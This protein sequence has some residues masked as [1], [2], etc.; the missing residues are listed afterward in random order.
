M[1]QDKT[2]SPDIPEG[3]MTVIVD[4]DWLRIKGST[5]TSWTGPDSGQGGSGFYIYAE[6]S[7]P[8]ELEH[9]TR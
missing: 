7:D 2:D 1:V 3:D 4:F 8:Q 9:H 6:S 5:P